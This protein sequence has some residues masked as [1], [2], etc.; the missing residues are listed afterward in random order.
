[1]KL[2][3]GFNF[4]KVEQDF[5]FVSLSHPLEYPFNEGRIVSNKGLDIAVSEWNDYFLEEHVERSNALHST[6]HGTR[7]RTTSGPLARY[8][9]NFEKLT[10]TARD[11]ALEA[12]L[13]P[14]DLNPFKSIIVRGIETLYAVEEALRIIDQYEEPAQ[15][16]SS[17]TSR[18]VSATVPARRPAGCCTTAMR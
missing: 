10:P 15:P 4:P 13:G 12:D 5:E 18:P 2:V 16:T 6:D 9:N 14:V 7:V 11:A 1:M 17:S 8:A 3:A